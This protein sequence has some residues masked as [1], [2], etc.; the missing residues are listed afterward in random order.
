MMAFGMSSC[1]SDDDD[2]NPIV[3]T[4]ELKTLGYPGFDYEIPLDDRD[5]FI[6]NSNGKLKVIKKKRSFFPDFPN[7]DGEYD[8]S[9][10]KAKK[11]IQ[12][13]GVA[14]ECIILNGEMRI[15]GYHEAD[16]EPVQRFIFIKK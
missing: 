13:C 11:I 2:D 10:D 12:L 4:W 8:Y 9:Y 3:G 15:D 7:E 16:S 1:S 5:L 14:R 6:F